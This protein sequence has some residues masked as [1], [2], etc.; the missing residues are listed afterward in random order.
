MHY[1]PKAHIFKH[2]FDFDIGYLV[3][4]PC[5][6]CDKAHSFPEC[7]DDCDVL[8]RIHSRLTEA[9]SSSRG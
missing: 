1:I 5:K 9:I 8:D 6:D 2:R 3:K 7:I 4:S